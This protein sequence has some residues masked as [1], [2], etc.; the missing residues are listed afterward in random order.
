MSAESG[1]LRAESNSNSRSASGM[2]TDKKDSMQYRRADGSYMP[3]VKVLVNGK[4]LTKVGLDTM[5]SDTLCTEMFSRRVGLQQGPMLDSM[6]VAT[7]TGSVKM[8]NTPTVSMTLESVN[9]IGDKI[10]LKN[11]PTVPCPIVINK[12]Q[13]DVEQYEHLRDLVFSVPE[14]VS[15]VDII[16]GVD[17][18]E[19]MCPLQ[20]HKGKKDEP[21]AT[22]T[23]FGMVLHGKKSVESRPV[24]GE[25]LSSQYLTTVAP[26][27]MPVFCDPTPGNELFYENPNLLQVVGSDVT[28]QVSHITSDVSTGKE[29]NQSKSNE[30]HITGEYELVS[31]A[32]GGLVQGPNLKP[33]AL[34]SENETCDQSNVIIPQEKVN[35]Q[36]HVEND[37][38]LTEVSISGKCSSPETDN[39]PVVPGKTDILVSREHMLNESSR[40]ENAYR[41]VV[42]TSKVNDCYSSIKE[43]P[44][45]FKWYK[46]VSLELQPNHNS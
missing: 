39:D 22:L 2:C 4:H 14:A 15:E 30:S 36:V 10:H 29:M 18:S 35:S 27:R 25:S 45:I 9:K 5:S 23:M 44:T 34:V 31:N 12:A 33:A 7:M 43:A 40:K 41:S 16:I 3:V 21:F 42:D 38:H 19:V 37:F 8:K 1:T 6:T 17:N 13:N 28:P 20:V 26:I 46:G 32:P 24:N 11:I